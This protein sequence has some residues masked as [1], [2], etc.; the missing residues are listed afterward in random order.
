[1]AYC[2]FLA[3]SDRPKGECRRALPGSTVRT[4]QGRSFDLGAV[5][6]PTS[7]PCAVINRTREQNNFEGFPHLTHICSLTDMCLFTGETYWGTYARVVE[8]R[9]TEENRTGGRYG[10]IPRYRPYRRTFLVAR[11]KECPLPIVAAAG[12]R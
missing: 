9:D 1:M 6:A 4:A 3:L 2:L 11:E 7:S 8:Y 12:A 5:N 10:S